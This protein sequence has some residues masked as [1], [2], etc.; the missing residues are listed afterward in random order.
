LLGGGD[1]PSHAHGP[2]TAGTDGDVDAEDASEEGHPG[3][4]TRC[5][6]AQLG[7]EQ[8]RDGGKLERAVRDEEG[9][10][11]GGRGLFGAWDD[12]SA[13]GVMAREDT[14]LKRLW[15]LMVIHSK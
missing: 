10:L 3:E 12:A 7:L 4:S 15:L 14:V 11:L 6:R 8:A 5:D 1:S 13:Q 2:A 9:E